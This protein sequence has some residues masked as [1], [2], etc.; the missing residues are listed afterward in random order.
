[1]LHISPWQLRHKDELDDVQKFFCQC[2]LE[3]RLKR[4]CMGGSKE[5]CDTLSYSTRNMSVVLNCNIAW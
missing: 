4:L 2:V 1:M 5:R 3:H